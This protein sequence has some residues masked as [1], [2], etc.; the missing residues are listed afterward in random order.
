MWVCLATGLMPLP[1][2]HSSSTQ[3]YRENYCSVIIP[4]KSCISVWKSILFSYK[5][6]VSIKKQKRKRN[7]ERKK[8]EKNKKT[9]NNP[10]RTLILSL[11]LHHPPNKNN[12]YKKKNPHQ[13]QPIKT[14][15]KKERK[16]NTS[17]KVQLF[18]FGNNNNKKSHNKLTNKKLPLW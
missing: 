12:I 2:C 18:L 16:K 14:Q 9:Q 4:I 1:L 8:T 5:L 10:V 15:I 17:N 13:G 11:S 7:E 6:G 3:D